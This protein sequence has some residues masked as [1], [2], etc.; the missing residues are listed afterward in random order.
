MTEFE[1]VFILYALLL[2]L[3]GIG[4]TT[5]SADPERALLGIVLVCSAGVPGL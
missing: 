5:L 2:G 4:K 3:S 1:F